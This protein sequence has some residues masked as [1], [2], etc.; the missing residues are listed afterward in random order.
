MNIR[1]FEKRPAR[2]A[3]LLAVV[4]STGGAL[5]AAPLQA[6]SAKTPAV[7]AELK[8]FKVSGAK[9]VAATSANPGEVIEYQARYT[10]TGSVP[11]TRFAPQLPVPDALVYVG[12]SAAPGAVQASVDGKNFAP[13]P[14][15]RSVKG[16]DGKSRLVAIPLREYKV[17]RWQL[18]ALAPG[19]SVT[20][21]ARA[22]V[23]AFADAR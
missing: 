17:L 21:K 7:Q 10:N 14:L 18:G 8:A 23:K 5:L 1:F 11:A 13:A 22:R 19:Q 9:L 2:V 12:D 20:V 15:M 4:F 6:Q 16:A 3:A